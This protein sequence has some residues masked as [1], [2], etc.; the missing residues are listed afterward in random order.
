MAHPA[1]HR[2]A[3][4]GSERRRVLLLMPVVAAAL[5]LAAGW[6]TGSAQ[7]P[8]SD[9]EPNGAEQ[10]DE[11][12]AASEAAGLQMVEAGRDH[13]CALDARGVVSC[14]G[15]DSDGQVSDWGRWRYRAQRFAQV[16]AGS[17]FSCGILTNGSVF[18]WGYPEQPDGGLSELDRRA[19]EDWAAD[20]DPDYE[21][22]VEAPPG[23]VKFR[24]GSLSVGNLHACAIRVG[25]ELACWGKA[26]DAR[27]V[28]PTGDDGAAITDWTTVEAGWAHACAIRAGGSVVCFGRTTHNRA[29]GPEGDG[30]FTAVTLGVYNGCALAGDGSVECWGGHRGL[31]RANRAI[32][33]P[34][35]DVKFS[36]IE[37]STTEFYS[38]GLTQVHES[39]ERGEADGNGETD[40]DSETEGE[41]ETGPEIRCWGLVT[42][43]AHAARV[44]PPVGSF[45]SLSVGSANS[46]ALDA[47]GELARWGDDHGRLLDPPEGVFT[48]TD[49]GADFSC[50]LK[51]DR[52]IVCWGGANA[53]QQLDAPDGAFEQLTV[54]D[55]HACALGTDERVVC[56]GG[57]RGDSPARH[58]AAI[59]RL[60]RFTS[61]D[62]GPDQTCGIRTG[63]FSFE[64]WG[65]LTYDRYNEP[66]GSFTQVAVGA[67]HVCAI[68]RSVSQGAGFVVCW[69]QTLFFDGD[70]DGRPDDTDG[71]GNHTTTSPPR[72]AHRYTEIS[73]GQGHTCAIRDDG[74]AVCWGYHADDRNRVPGSDESSQGF[75]SE[76]YVDIATGGPMNCAIRSSDGSLD[77]WNTSQP[78]YQPSREVLGLT[79]LQSLGAGTSHMCAID[80]D[81]GL[82]CWGAGSAL[83]PQ[84]TEFSSAA[85]SCLRGDVAG[86]Y[87]LVVH[88]GGPLDELPDCARERQVRALHVLREGRYVSWFADGPDFLNARFLALWES[89]D[90]DWPAAIPAGTVL[91]AA[92]AGPDSADLLS[93]PAIPSAGWHSCLRGTI[94]LD[95]SPGMHLALYEGGSIE[96]LDACA[97]EHALSAVHVLDAGAWVSYAVGA[98]ASDNQAF[99]ELFPE[100]LP[101]AVP[102]A[103]ERRADVPA[104]D[105]GSQRP[106]TTSSSPSRRPSWPPESGPRCAG[107]RCGSRASPTSAADW[108]ST[109]RGAG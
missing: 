103:V 44:T 59:A 81:G 104:S 50:A 24:P 86:G 37:M 19:W 32:N 39:E 98:P 30:P 10:A 94:G 92:S 100:D 13:A 106:T 47:G 27:L 57:V 64:C 42:N 65:S 28:V 51:Q 85:G 58:P 102:V 3:I 95:M 88:A 101:A 31:G 38:C 25:G 34:P 14:W 62:A 109:M 26:G 1:P 84:P 18:C 53:N 78:R 29:D 12:D 6:H 15:E 79:G 8:P 89:A 4:F 61:V 48:Q 17:V 76:E 69:G 73:A 75:G 96:S 45:A 41:D 54:G 91:L 107:G 97:R 23:A 20:P 21:G 16:S 5:L 74:R 63:G 108:S 33:T 68:R 7:D 83:V 66:A 46:Y 2:S 67:T 77:C 80:R 90:P 11:P 70:G 35:P 82:V 56:W 71:F 9:E 105:P 60:G 52:T 72:G 22:W 99:T 87:S 43:N 49:G 93:G 55:S 36:A 40:G